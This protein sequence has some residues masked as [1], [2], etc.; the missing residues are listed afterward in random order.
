MERQGLHRLVANERKFKAKR[1][2]KP[3]LLPAIL[4]VVL[5]AS[6]P[7]SADLNRM[8]PK[9]STYVSM[10]SS[11]AAGAGIG[12]KQTGSPERC[13]RTTNNYASL[14]AANF[15]L[16]LVDVSCGG[17]TTAHI[18]G[19]WNELPPQINAIGTSTRL[20]TV[21]IGGNDLGLVGWL[22]ASSCRLGASVLPG[23]CRTASEPADID[24][25]TV[26]R[27]IRRISQVVHARAPQARLIY[28]QYLTVNSAHPCP[29][30]AVSQEDAIIAKRIARRLAAV[31]KTAAREGGAEVLE[32]D[33]LSRAHTPCSQQPWSHGFYKSYQQGFG[34]PWHPNAAGHA[35]IARE[36]GKV[37]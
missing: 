27:N 10:G 5:I 4:S 3:I 19:P 9:G 13:D 34:A 2:M 36:L 31:T 12:P 6:T 14:V 17:A 7:G 21:T 29:L 18:L 22:F 15:G 28:V 24:F 37:L 26:S 35:A 8:I 11:Y 20:V 30:E 1:T 25:D 32:T 23:P 33:V 16:N